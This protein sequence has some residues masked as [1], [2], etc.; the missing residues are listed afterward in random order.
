MG[1][2]LSAS[3]AVYCELEYERI[4]QRIGNVSTRCEIVG[5]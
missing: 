2:D 3:G 1:L 4:Q 5:S